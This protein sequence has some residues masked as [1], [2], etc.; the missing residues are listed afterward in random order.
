MSQ[1]TW[2]WRATRSRG[3]C[4]T[5]VSTRSGTTMSGGSGDLSMNLLDLSTPQTYL[6]LVSSTFIKLLPT[7]FICSS[8]LFA[9]RYLQEDNTYIFIVYSV[10]E[11]YQAPSEKVILMVP[12]Y[13]KIRAISITIMVTVA[14][15]GGAFAIFYYLRKRCFNTLE[16][17]KPSCNSS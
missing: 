12:A 9:V 8:L 7:C 13:K 14:L 5:L 15:I 3:T 16:E 6:I 1:F 10:S 11:D 17:K 4:Q 2:W